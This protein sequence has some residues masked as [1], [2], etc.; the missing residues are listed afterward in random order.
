M[1][2]DPFRELGLG[3][4]ASADDVRAAR[5]RLAWEHHPDRGG[6]PAAMR[7][8][9]DAYRRAMA[10][11]SQRQPSDRVRIDRDH[12]S[13]VIELLPIEAFEALL[14]ATSWIGEVLV[15]EPPYLLEVQLHDPAPCWCRLELVPDAG[16]STVSLTVDGPVSAEDVRNVWITVLHQLGPDQL[17]DGP[18]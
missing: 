7:A 10:L 6:D 5:R 16:A 14:V 4:G 17:G 8:L 3:S 2:A 1:T 11:I 9:N 12:P 13:F 15:D 18:P